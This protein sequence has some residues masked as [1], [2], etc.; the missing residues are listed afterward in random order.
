[1]AQEPYGFSPREVGEMTLY[2][3]KTLL[4][5]EESLGTGTFRVDSQDYDRVKVD[6]DD[7]RK[8]KGLD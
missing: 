3:I 1:M 7:D 4:A 6:I 5:R 2:Q 8:A